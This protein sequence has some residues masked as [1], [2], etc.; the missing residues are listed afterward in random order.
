M[1]GREQAVSWRI[2][3]YVCIWLTNLWRNASRRHHSAHTTPTLA[4]RIELQ[5]M[6]CGHRHASVVTQSLSRRICIVRTHCL[7]AGAESRQRANSRDAS[8]LM[9]PLCPST[10]VRLSACR[11]HRGRAFITN[12]LN[13]IFAASP[14][15]SAK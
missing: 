13:E 4:M 14:S 6:C 12:G 15:S 11:R 3:L 2:T 10:S 7:E 8:A 9:R 1:G 5:K